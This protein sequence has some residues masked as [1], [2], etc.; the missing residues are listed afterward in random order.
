M[1]ALLKVANTKLALGNFKEA[2]NMYLDALNNCKSSSDSVDVYE[3]LGNYYEITGQMDKCI[4]TLKLKYRAMEKYMM[5]IQLNVTRA[6]ELEKYSKAGR[7]DEALAQIQEIKSHL[8]PPYDQLISIAYVAIYSIQDNPDSIRN[9][10]PALEQMIENLNFE[11]MRSYAY[12]AEGRIAELEGDYEKSAELFIKVLELEPD[13]YGGNTR[14]GRVYRKGGKENKAERYLLESLKVRP[15]DPEANLEM[16]YLYQQKGEREK[17]MDYLNKSL[18]A[19][20]NAD[21]EFKPAIMAREL[22]AELKGN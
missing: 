15:S 1:S 22:Y 9:T 7:E 6:V 12:Y 3:A 5:A 14:I 4:E 20:E 17:G 2:Y 16:A 19:W 10:L 18:L 8:I 21:P 13:N 11:I